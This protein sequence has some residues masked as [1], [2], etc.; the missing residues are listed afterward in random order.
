VQ[1]ALLR[2]VCLEVHVLRVSASI[3]PEIHKPSNILCRAWDIFLLV[4]FYKLTIFGESKISP[5]NIQYPHPAVH[6]LARVIL[7]GVYSFWA[8]LVGTGI[9]ILGKSEK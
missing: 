2:K 9:W 6:S 8:G 7:W 3:C 4:A 5:E 1:K